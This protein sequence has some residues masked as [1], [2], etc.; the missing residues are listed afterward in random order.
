MPSTFPVCFKEEV[1]NIGL[2]KEYFNFE[3][4][5]HLN[6]LNA[7]KVPEN[8][9]ENLPVYVVNSVK[10]FQTYFF[11]NIKISTWDGDGPIPV[12]S[13]YEYLGDYDKEFFK[14]KS[15][16]L[17]FIEWHTGSADFE[18]SDIIKSDNA[19]DISVK[20]LYSGMTCDLGE[21]IFIVEVDK[22][23]LDGITEYNASINS[24]Y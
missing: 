5:A 10:D 13:V 7:D 22:D 17:V 19:I 6:A 8:G 4:D 24:P 3:K 15:L 14:N 18:I 21:W 12:E 16:I 23:Y 9:K 1:F 20:N 2:I 11:G